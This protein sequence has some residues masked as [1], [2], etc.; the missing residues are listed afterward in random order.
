MM[1]ARM[2]CFTRASWQLDNREQPVE[3]L[4]RNK[5]ATVESLRLLLEAWP[6]IVHKRNT[7]RGTVLHQVCG[8]S[9]SSTRRRS[10]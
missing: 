9:L 7:F 1:G 2:K 5:V 6:D 10:F 8:F 3:M 4:L